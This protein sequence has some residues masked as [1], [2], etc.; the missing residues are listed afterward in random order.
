[1]EK[2]R[3][4]FSAGNDEEKTFKYIGFKVQQHS[5]KVILDHSDYIVNIRNSVVQGEHQRKMVC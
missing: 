5:N 1:M 2:L 3:A 4:R